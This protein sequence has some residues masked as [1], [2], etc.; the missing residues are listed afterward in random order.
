LDIDAVV[1]TGF[2]GALTLSA[3]RIAALAL[4]YVETADALL[5]DGSIVASRADSAHVLWNGMRRRVK[6]Y[7]SVGDALVGMTLM[8]GCR[9]CMDIVGGGR[10]TI[11]PLS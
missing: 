2:T 6:V 10:M 7:E 5:A 4:P 3:G 9:L 11:E 8:H 1:D